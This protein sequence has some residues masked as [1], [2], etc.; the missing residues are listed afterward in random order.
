MY[1]AV[2]S[3]C[4]RMR[5]CFDCLNVP[6]INGKECVLSKYGFCFSYSSGLF[7]SSEDFRSTE[8]RYCAKSDRACS[9]CRGNGN[10]TSAQTLAPTSTVCKGKDGCI[11]LERCEKWPQ[12]QLRCTSAP[13]EPPVVA[14]RNGDGGMWAIVTIAVLAVILL[15]L[16]WCCGSRWQRRRPSQHRQSM[17]SVRETMAQRPT[18]VARQRQSEPLVLEGW[19][20]MRKSLIDNERIQL[21]YARAS[22]PAR[23]QERANDD[24]EVDADS[25]TAFI[26]FGEQ[27]HP[28][29]RSHSL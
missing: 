7:S 10:A 13:T 19:H 28:H 27:S 29:E 17:R 3:S 16:V 5:S 25:A 11:C 1:Q 9:T 6:L 21:G 14:Q 18:M 2:N 8:T 23:T 26:E 22:M 4:W 15:V 24:A 20:A 12:D